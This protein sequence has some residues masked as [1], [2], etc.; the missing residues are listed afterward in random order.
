MAA[1]IDNLVN[2]NFIK[3]NTDLLNFGLKLGGSG[4]HKPYVFP[5]PLE[6]LIFALFGASEQGAIYIPQPIVN[7]SQALFQ[8]SAGTVPV[9]AD[10]DP[11]GR[12]LDQSGNGNHAIQTVSG[13]RP[14]YR[15]DGTLHWLQGNGDTLVTDNLAFMSGTNTSHF[16]VGGAMLEFVNNGGIITVA[17]NS[18]SNFSQRSI[19]ISDTGW[20]SDV[21]G[22][23]IQTN[24]SIFSVSVLDALYLNG[25]TLGFGVFP[26]YET[27]SE[28]FNTA[29]GILS[30]GTGLAGD[31]ENKIF[32]VIALDREMTAEQ[33]KQ[34]AECIASLSGV[35]V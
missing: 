17:K 19:S 20:R 29:N 34:S 4:Q 27:A 5:A 8:D 10:G 2:V 26:E 32:G 30:L 12:M 13:S 21:R 28:S 33:K 16:I 25:N 24:S 15:T 6:T 9:T 11:V 3:G 31:G 35:T 18:G 23:S 22:R 14:V 7:G 1:S